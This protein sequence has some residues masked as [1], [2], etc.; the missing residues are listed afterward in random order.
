MCGIVGLKPSYGRVSRHGLIAMASSC[1]Q[2]GPL[3][4][5][6]HDAALVLN[7][8]CG[9]DIFDSTT[10]NKPVPDFTAKLD[11]SIKGLK[12][13]V[14]KEFFG[15]GLAPEVAEKIKEGTKKL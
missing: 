11:L 14:P 13:G 1:D 9:H 2:T 7:A 10:V 5:A 6:V 8:L 3:T 12:I 15:G 4:K